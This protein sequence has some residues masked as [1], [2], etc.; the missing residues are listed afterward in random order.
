MPRDAGVMGMRDKDLRR[1]AEHVIYHTEHPQAD[2]IRGVKV[3]WSYIRFA[4]WAIPI[5][6]AHGYIGPG[7]DREEQNSTEATNGTF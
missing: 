3:A 5:L 2:P 6:V 4:A 1:V 7:S